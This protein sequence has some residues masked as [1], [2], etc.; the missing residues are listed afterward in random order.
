MIPSQVQQVRSLLVIRQVRTD[1]VDH[2]HNERAIIHI[3]PVGATDEFIGTISN[4]WA[5]GILG[6]VWL[7]KSRHDGPSFVLQPLLSHLPLDAIVFM[8]LIA[9]RNGISR[10]WAQSRFSTNPLVN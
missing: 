8:R 6:Q 9:A 1:A 4:E 2:H 7:V 10:L 3:H 5:V